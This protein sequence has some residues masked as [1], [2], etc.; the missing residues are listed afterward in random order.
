MILKNYFVIALR[1]FW[2]NRLFAFINIFSLAVGISASVLLFMY[3]RSEW[4]YDHHHPNAERIYR[5]P[6]ELKS[7]TTLDRVAQNNFLF[8]V[9][10]KEYFPDVIENYWRVLS[11][12]K[13]P[14]RVENR[15][16]NE[17]KIAFTDQAFLDCLDMPLLVGDRKTALKDSATC[18]LTEAMAIKYFGTVRNA[19]GKSLQFP[20]K[21]YKVTGILKPHIAE[22]YFQ[23]QIYLSTPSIN[24]SFV[25][26]SKHD[27]MWLTTH[28]YV[29]LKQGASAQKLEKD[30]Q[31]NYL[32]YTSSWFEGKPRGEIAIKFLLQ[33]LKDIHLD[34]SFNNE[35]VPTNN[36]L[37][38]YILSVIGGFIL[39]MACINYMNLATARAGQRAREVG[40]RKV[41]GASRRQLLAQFLGESFV[42]ACLST[43]LG[44]AIAEILLPNFNY[45]TG[46]SFA[47]LPWFDAEFWSLSICLVLCISLLA[48]AYPALYLSSF[49][50]TWVLQNKTKQGGSM[51][52][53]WLNPANLRKGLVILQFGLSISLMIGTLIAYSQWDYMRTQPLGYQKENVLVIDIPVGDSL[54]V[55]RLPTLQKELQQ[56]PNIIGSCI[57]STVMDGHIPKLEHSI[58]SEDH[59]SVE[60]LYTL[61]IDEK[62]IPLL[63][64]ELKQGKNFLP[65]HHDSTHTSVIINEALA[66]KMGWKNPIGK[67][68][69]NSFMKSD[70]YQAGDTVHFE[71]IGIV[72]DFH[73]QSLQHKI[74]PLVMYYMPRN[75]GYV[76]VKFKP[77]QAKATEAWIRQKWEAFDSKHSI[78]A[79]NLSQYINDRYEPQGKL[80]TIFG[81]FSLLA[82]IISGL[83][84]LGLTSYL[85]EQ[86]SKEIGIRRVLGA[87][88]GEVVRLFALEFVWLVAFAFLLASPVVYTL[89][90]RWLQDF[91][92][93]AQPRASHFLLAGTSALCIAVATVSWLTWRVARRKPSLALRYG[94]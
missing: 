32:K 11:I 37:Y 58:T 57:T 93:H 7:E 43:C 2:R 56:N 67:T 22:T 84:L 6:L 5:I 53:W 13:Q 17:D 27:V 86:R 61:S 29:L 9:M 28:V 52:F 55:K 75:Y 68:I 46:K 39:L 79:F 25:T 31:K 80:V 16:F 69:A 12:G 48:G 66:Q 92:Y 72:K 83:G 85:T 65:T 20:I 76:M 14:V 77:T 82:I 70:R 18:V 4:R 40:L 89:M 54:L 47:Q 91:A 30:L 1:H 38:L 3:L 90:L 62:F 33:P 74:E 15:T 44:L 73:F 87:S 64:V 34:A 49:P 78:E 88:A 41:L 35:I 21:R 50:P 63:G 8:P 51:G 10:L 24:R 45:L 60:A 26:Q 42:L 36:P 81:Y 23:H 59:T 94:G 71:V 19:V